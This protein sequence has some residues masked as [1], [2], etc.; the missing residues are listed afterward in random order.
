MTDIT[1]VSEQIAFE[2]E[3]G[4][5]DEAALRD[6]L[7]AGVIAYYAEDDTPPGH[8]VKHYPDGRR[9]L[10]RMEHGRDHLVRTL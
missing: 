2:L 8:A 4:E 7:S 3:H 10:I 9:E 1:D 6:T 5:E